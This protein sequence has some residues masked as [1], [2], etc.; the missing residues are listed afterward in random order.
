MIDELASYGPCKKT[1]TDKVVSTVLVVLVDEDQSLDHSS[2]DHHIS[3][4]SSSGSS[5]TEAV[6]KVAVYVLKA[7]LTPS[8][9]IR[10][11]GL[12]VDLAKIESIC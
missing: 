2:E 5:S 3:E 9:I 6:S 10:S 12:S 1:L 11:S 4:K 7:S 8:H